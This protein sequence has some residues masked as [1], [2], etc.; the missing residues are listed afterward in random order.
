MT[1]DKKKMNTFFLGM[2]LG[3]DPHTVGIHNAG[4]IAKMLDIDYY[5]APTDIDLEVQLELIAK[6]NPKFLG[7]SY[8]LSTEKAIP[9]LLKILRNMEAKGLMDSERKICFAALPNT[10]DAVRKSGIEQAYHLTLMGQSKNIDNTTRATVNFFDPKS[11]AKIKSIIETIHRENEP[12]RIKIL[13]QLARDVVGNDM[14]RNTSPLP[15]PSEQ[16]RNFYTERMKESDIPMLRTHFGIPSDSIDPT[17]EGINVISKARVVDEIS[18]GSS[19]LS[20]RY[21]GN[22]EM[23]KNKKNDGGVP[24]KNEFDLECLYRASRTGNYPSVKPYCHVNNMISFADTCKKIGLLRGGHQAVPLFWFS[25]LDGRG[26]YSVPKAISEHI[27]LVQHLK[28]F[29]IPVEMNDPNQWSS[30]FAH[31]TVFVADYALI[32][33]VLYMNGIENLC[34]QMQFNKPALTGDYGDL[35]KMNAARDLIEFV[36]PEKNQARILIET[37]SGIEHFS[38]ELEYAK[39]QLARTTLLQMFM[40]PDIIHLVSYCEADH[41]ATPEDIIESSQIVRYAVQLFK[42]NEQEIRKEA[43]HPFVDQRKDYLKEEAKY[44]LRKI[45]SY[46]TKFEENNI[47]ASLA[48]PRILLNAMETRLMTAPGI[49]CEAYKNTQIITKANEYGVIDCVSDWNDVKPMP[50]AERIKRMGL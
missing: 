43:L 25:E 2:S 11:D 46:D 45:A 10:L 13:D 39:Y 23:F 6:Y 20:Q 8:R 30:R 19:D 33:A 12:E 41:A 29:Q 7:L 35:A 18:L 47:A 24:Y 48:K 4:R 36:R 38:T 16:A 21:F 22:L 9:E 28:E 27:K 49:N 42:K 44:L 37:R 5:V 32:A 34:F 26:D 14:Y 1:G 15:I 17:V 40:N 3:H 31:D 50:E